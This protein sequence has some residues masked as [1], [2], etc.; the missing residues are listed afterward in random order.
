MA[1]NQLTTI[2]DQLDLFPFEDNTPHIESG[3][4]TIY[5]STE[6][7]LQ[8]FDKNAYK[9]SPV[10]EDMIMIEQFQETARLG[11]EL[12]VKLYAHRSITKTIINAFNEAKF[13]TQTKSDEV[14]R[15][16][17][18]LLKPLFN[19]AR[20]LIKFRD[21]TT[22]YICDIVRRMVSSKNR[23]VFQDIIEALGVLIDNYVL[24]D[25]LLN[26][27]PSFANDFS[28]YKRE[29]SFM[30]D[31]DTESANITEEMHLISLF[32]A[33]KYSLL[34]HLKTKIQ[35]IEQTASVFEVIINH[36]LDLFLNQ[37]YILPN[38]KNRQVRMIATCLIL[39]DDP[40]NEKKNPFKSKSIPLTKIGKIFKQQPFFLLFGD[41]SIKIEEYLQQ[42]PHFSTVIWGS[43]EDKKTIQQY[44]LTNYLTQERKQH[45]SYVSEFTQK[46]NSI[47]TQKANLENL[48]RDQRKDVVELVLRGIRLI[49][50]WTSKILEQAA[51]KYTHATEDAKCP[52]GATDY[53]RVVRYNYTT[54]ELST[55]VE[56]IA[57]VKGLSY[58]M[59]KHD[60]LISTIFR[61]FIYE[62]IQDFVQNTLRPSI[63]KAAK[64]KKKPQTRD[65]LLLIR[66][67]FADWADEK[68]PND[69]AVI[70]KNYKNTFQILSK[71]AGISKTQLILLR[72]L[73]ENLLFSLGKKGEVIK[74]KEISAKAVKAIE[75]FL[76]KTLYFQYLVNFSDI[77]YESSNL[78]H[79]WYREFHLELT[80]TIQF[81]IEMSLPWI[82]TH[83]ALSMR[84]SYVAEM[85]LFPLSL[86]DDSCDCAVKILKE[87]FIFEEIQAEVNL[88]FDQ[89]AFELAESMF[90][91]YKY[92]SSTILLDKEF[93]AEIQKLKTA[94]N[95][96][97]PP[98]S[99]YH[100][101]AVQRHFSLLGR[102][103]NLNKLIS[104][105]MN[106]IIRENIN[107]AIQR[108]ESSNISGIF[109]LEELLKNIKMTHFLLSQHFELDEFDTI[110]N[111]INESISLV[112][113]QGRIVLH[114]IFEFIADV[115]PN[116]V[117]NSTTQ[118]FT[119]SPRTYAEKVV[120]D[121][122]PR[123]PP[124]FL[125]GS[126]FLNDSY[127]SIADLK[128]EFFGIPHILSI[129]RIIGEQNLPLI[130]QEC[131][132][133]V[134]LKIQ[135]VLAPYVEEL[136]NGISTKTNLP[137]IDY[138]IDGCF[139]YFEL[140]LDPIRKYGPLESEVFQNFR[141]LGNTIILMRL[142]EQAMTEPHLKTFIN[143][144]PFLCLFPDKFSFNDDDDNNNDN[145]DYSNLINFQN[146]N[147]RSISMV[148][149]QLQKILAN[150]EF[151]QDF[152]PIRDIENFS[153]NTESVYKIKSK[154]LSLF[155]AV[156][157]H[158]NKMLDPVRSKWLGNFQPGLINFDR[159]NEFYRLW[160]CLQFMFCLAPAEENDEN[161]NENENDNDNLFSHQETFGDGFS[162]AGMT[163][164]Y[165]LNQ[166]ELFNS[167]DF[168]YHLLYANDILKEKA[169]SV[170]QTYF[171]DNAKYLRDLNNLI[172][173][174]LD[175]YVPLPDPQIQFFE[176][177]TEEELQKI[178]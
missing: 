7:S 145:S 74:C 6:N 126:K 134:E 97:N 94:S 160:S 68:I 121:A 28:Q 101:L 147:S 13:D 8:F 1:N 75:E 84:S 25:L 98:K 161:E 178:K 132:T 115:I 29:F 10:L 172:F 43:L 105:K 32:F 31:D 81:P 37:S 3:E 136:L 61:S 154:P 83:H 49:S 56:F 64:N 99:R 113:L 129:L 16:R 137:S 156:L 139:G 159:S 116:F 93:R 66:T 107:I 110:F 112:S 87:Q 19:T 38:E 177:P 60:Y 91:H 167:L 78:S 76:H 77:V 65:K 108:F 133:N 20:K 169:K 90:L 149:S 127:E 17:M 52:L 67:L 142:F 146:K 54:K 72:L 124:V 168:S 92:W 117:Y 135:N 86:Y 36:Y 45:N 27:K 57:M 2:F 59:A 48:S 114:C 104:Q 158:V 95:E 12:F 106:N 51:Y 82:L 157:M 118:R 71:S 70:G 103:I 153:Q 24:L 148:T 152:I 102:T 9:D 96:L 170:E 33:N 144:A 18:D 80:K 109:L 73:A 120:R 141:E 69:P 50:S 166:K 151:S 171:L 130:A 125:F 40:K 150:P 143:S 174:F 47:K 39:L 53:E 122:P 163:I 5:Y 55:L 123:I 30:H 46:I 11:E 131:L 14:H 100:I 42:A 140:P 165:F 26:Q 62:E 128:S 34:T 138:G 164:I 22:D 79:L 23:V 162:W 173:S 175:S 35:E 58:F 119:R 111:E 15:K 63:K 88:C 89:L 176:P 85:M 44:L 4:P 21:E 41:M 155:K